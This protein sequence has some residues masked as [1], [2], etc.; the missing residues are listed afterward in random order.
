MTK[1][2]TAKIAKRQRAKVLTAAAVER[3]RA[4]RKRR[5]IHDGGCSGLFLIIQPTGR[6][7]WAMRLRRPNGKPAKLYLG[8]VNLS[9]KETAGEPVI[10]APQ[11]LASAR[12]LV[13]ELHLQRKRNLDVVGDHL[14]P[15]IG[16]SSRL[17]SEVA[18]P[19]ARSLQV[20]SMSTPS[21]KQGAG[22]KPLGCS[23]CAAVMMNG[24]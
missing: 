24:R 3:Y 22:P 13:A 7:S 5:E 2:H 20:S 6:K 18:A 1:D 8:P 14:E 12:V 10:G 17:R 21:R 4:T 23:G 9:G 19:S 11:T 16:A 15:S